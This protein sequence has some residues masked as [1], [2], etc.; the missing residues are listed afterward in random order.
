MIFFSNFL[1]VNMVEVKRNNITCANEE[2]LR[3]TSQIL[4]QN[5]LLINESVIE[6]KLKEKYLCVKSVKSLRKFPNKILLEVSAREALAQ[7]L[8]LKNSE[9]TSSAILD[10]FSKGSSPSAI[11]QEMFNTAEEVDKS[12]LVDSEGVFFSK[13]PQNFNYPK[14][15]VEDETVAVKDVLKIINKLKI[16]GI[17][18]RET[19]AVGQKILLVNPDISGPKMIFA[20]D[21]IDIQL[22]SLQL[23]LKKAKIDQV[24]IE[25]IDL[26]FDKPIVRFAPKK[27]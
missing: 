19:R 11:P 10:T 8:V 6:K 5:I 25:F 4:G 23:I 27:K 21:N 20:L 15:Y 9:A 3:E 16:F 26:R 14:V 12:F 24:T 2:E 18:I 13:D 1:K 7:I 22:A 17:E